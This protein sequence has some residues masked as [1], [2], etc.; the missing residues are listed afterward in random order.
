MKYIM[1]WKIY[2]FYFFKVFIHKLIFA[3]GG[4]EYVWWIEWRK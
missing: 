2:N 4:S 1:N 3:D